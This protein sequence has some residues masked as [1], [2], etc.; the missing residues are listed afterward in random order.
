VPVVDATG[1]GATALDALDDALVA[2]GV[3]NYNLVAYSSI[4]P[5]GAAVERHGRFPSGRY[6]VGAPVG[7]VAATATSADAPVAAGIGWA[8]A[9]EGG[10]FFEAAGADPGVV[11]REIRA[12][13]AGARGRRDWAWHDDEA[14]VVADRRSPAGGEG[15]A[16]AVVVAVHGRLD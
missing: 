8:R 5:A 12:G 4:L 11:E 7:V 6:P 2:A 14:V 3:G 15:A 1:A 13:L 9:D 16:A 10:V